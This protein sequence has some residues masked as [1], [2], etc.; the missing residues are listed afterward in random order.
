MQ[1]EREVL[2]RQKAEFEEKARGLKAYTHELTEMAAKHGTDDA[3]LEQDLTEARYNLQHYES[4][5]EQVREQIEKGPDTPTYMLYEDSAGE[6]RW[7]LRSGNNRIIAD[8]GEG[9]SNKQ[10]CLHAIE[11]VKNSRDAEVKEK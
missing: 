8:S 9:Y 4:M 5:L 6:W 1:G 10:D 3:L 11:L 7:Q 2:E